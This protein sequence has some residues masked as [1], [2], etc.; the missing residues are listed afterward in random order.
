MIGYCAT[1]RNGIAS[2]PQRL[3]SRARTEAKTGR[4][5]K[6]LA[7]IRSFSARLFEIAVDDDTGH[8]RAYLGN[9]GWRNAAGQLADHRQRRRLQFNHADFRK[10]RTV[11]AAG[12]GRTFAA[13]GDQPGN[14]RAVTPLW[15]TKAVILFQPLRCCSPQAYGVGGTQSAHR[16]SP[17]PGTPAS[18]WF[19]WFLGML[20]LLG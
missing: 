3:M 18:Q 9:P 11:L 13:A 8:A 15:S 19:R 16:L 10:L 17:N 6:K 5:M 14:S 20:R 1:A 12:S 7:S 2:A 4:S